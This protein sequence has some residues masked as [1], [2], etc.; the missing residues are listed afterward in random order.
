MATTADRVNVELRANLAGLSRDLTNAAGQFERYEKRTV[1]SARNSAD[2]QVREAKRGASAGAQMATRS[3]RASDLR[4][5]A[6]SALATASAVA[7]YR[8][9]V[10]PALSNLQPTRMAEGQR[11]QVAALALLPLLGQAAA[12]IATGLATNYLY[13]ELTS[14]DLAKIGPAVRYEEVINRLG[15]SNQETSERLSSMPRGERELEQ[16]RVRLAIANEDSRVATAR[17]G[18]VDIYAGDMETLRHLL[19][20]GPG[21]NPDQEILGIHREAEKRLQDFDQFSRGDISIA[22]FTSR[23]IPTD[24]LAAEESA[25]IIAA[26]DAESDHGPRTKVLHEKLRIVNASLGVANQLADGIAGALAGTAEG[27]KRLLAAAGKVL[28]SNG[29]GS[30]PLDIDGASPLPHG[31]DATNLQRA[32]LPAK[33]EV[34][35]TG[36]SHARVDSLPDALTVPPEQQHLLDLY[37]QG[38]ELTKS[39]RTEQEKLTEALAHYDELLQARAISQET[40]DRLVETATGRQKQLAGAITAVGDVFTNGIKGAKDFN[41]ALDSIGLGLLDLAAKGLFGQGALGGVFNQ[42]LDVETGGAGLLSLFGGPSGG[43][44]WDGIGSIFGNLFGGIFGRASGGQV[45]PGRL[46]EVGEAGR[47]WFAPSVPGQVIP[48]HVIKAAAG[49]GGGAGQPITFNISMA[50]ANGDRTIAE[51]AAAAVKKGLASV[52]EINRQHRIRFA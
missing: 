35:A 16:L 47:E 5:P 39:A 50:G 26:S 42:L 40:Y 36:S 9:L 51:I 22:E 44:F 28:P 31:Q 38:A 23:A 12:S 45:L 25:A 8:A 7:D 2:A 11:V 49:G 52:P 4:P 17:A 18:I 24:G 19:A 14:D 41:D 20:R 21:I 10:Q 33:R 29:A 15:S 34:P 6:G 27:T 32:K 1:Q 37:K 30:M 13:D 48:N 3:G 43:G 46:Y